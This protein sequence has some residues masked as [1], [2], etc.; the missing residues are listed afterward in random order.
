[1]AIKPYLQLIRLP[2]VFTAAADSLAGWLLVRGS[3]DAPERWL[4]LVGASMAIYAAGIALNDVFDY[5][6]D[7]KERPGRP[8][9]SGLVSRRFAAWGGG[10]LLLLGPLLAALSGS[11]AS[12]GIALALAACVLAYNLGLKRTWF[13]PEVMGSCR[14][15]NLVLGM[16]QAVDFGGPGGWIVGVSLGVFVTGVTWISRSETEV[17]RTRG[18]YLGL[19]LENL[20][21]L[22]L[23]TAALQPRLFPA[24]AADPRAVLPLEGMLV[25][26]LVAW[27]VNL[28]GT[29]ALQNPI[30]STLQKAVKTGVLSLVWLNVGVVAA[31]RGPTLAASVAI[32][33][34]PA[35]LLGRWL[36]ST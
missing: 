36:Y 29:R 27:V 31:V 26:L 14:A 11:I 12:V 18:L 32:L 15:L 35:F 24:V 5:E 33:W 21:F 30:P 6:I 9:P 28:A 20:A 16:S 2:N 13:G 4:P 25:L 8:L 10:S 1:M 19:T 7:L 34:I 3:L 17:G 22:G 23:L